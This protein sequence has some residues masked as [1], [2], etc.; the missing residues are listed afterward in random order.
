MQQPT[1]RYELEKHLQDAFKEH[2][3]FLLEEL[4]DWE[5]TY[6]YLEA[7]DAYVKRFPERVI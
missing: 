7:R 2:V 4:G 6:I 3:S 5:L 1:N